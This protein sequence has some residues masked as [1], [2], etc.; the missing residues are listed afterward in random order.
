MSSEPMKEPGE[1]SPSEIAA[2]LAEKLYGWRP[3]DRRVTGDNMPVVWV[4][5]N[6]GRHFNFEPVTDQAL[7]L[8]LIEAAREKGIDS[9]IAVTQDGWNVMATIGNGRMVFESLEIPLADVPKQT[10][11]AILVALRS[12]GRATK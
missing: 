7:V 10:A 9:A 6:N 4:D 5:E 11:I 1:M 3:L 8:P 12:K 2:E